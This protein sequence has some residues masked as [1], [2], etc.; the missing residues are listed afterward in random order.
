MQEIEAKYY[1]RNLPAAEA[2]IISEGGTLLHAR[3]HETNLRFDTPDEVLSRQ[4]QMLRLRKSH[5]VTITYKGTM[6]IHDGVSHRQEIE[7]EMG[8]FEIA[9]SLLE[10]LGYRVTRIYEKYRTEFLLDGLTIALDELP[11]GNFVEIEGTGSEKIRQTA[12]RLG[13]NPA[14]NI[15]A[16]YLMLLDQLNKNRHLTLRDLTFENLNG[17]TITPEDLSVTPAD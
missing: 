6:S 1:V 12:A 11:Y 2:K 5:T 10:A 14:V 13:L 4:N 9:K 16:N 15:P 8:D 17:L 7:T 3:I